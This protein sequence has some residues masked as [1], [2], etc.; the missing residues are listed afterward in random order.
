MDTV[1]SSL[2]SNLNTIGF[3]LNATDSNLDTMDSNLN[4]M[5]SNVST[6]D[7]TFNLAAV[8]NNSKFNLN[9]TYV[10]QNEKKYYEIAG[11]FQVW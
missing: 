2:N 9:N 6:I 4:N 5:D 10:D 11:E 7:C 3:N 8:Y 1:D